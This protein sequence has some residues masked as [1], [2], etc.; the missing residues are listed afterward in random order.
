VCGWTP[1][2]AELLDQASAEDYFW[3][4]VREPPHYWI[5]GLLTACAAR[6]NPYPNYRDII[7]L[8][9]GGALTPNKELSGYIFLLPPSVF[10]AVD[11]S[12]IGVEY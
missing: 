5:C 7:T 2:A 9:V 11:E 4:E 3:W 12:H 10:R 6:C 1:T 8:W